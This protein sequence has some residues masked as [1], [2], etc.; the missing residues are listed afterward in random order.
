MWDVTAI[1]CQKHKALAYIG[2]KESSKAVLPNEYHI[3]IWEILLQLSYGS[4]YQI[5]MWLKESYKYFCNS[6]IS[7]KNL[8]E[9]Q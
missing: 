8:M 4:T 6:K 3:H 7:I 2:F 1:S 9:F 5:W